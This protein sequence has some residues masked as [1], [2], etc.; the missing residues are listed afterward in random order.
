[1]HCVSDSIKPL[2]IGAKPLVVVHSLGEL[3]RNADHIPEKKAGHRFP[4]SWRGHK[5]EFILTGMQLRAHDI[6]HVLLGTTQL[7][8][9]P[10][11]RKYFGHFS[12]RRIK[13]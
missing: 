1:M 13:P 9:K 6:R 8:A 4:G 11:I 7:T 3:G 5:V 10:D 2:V 12:C